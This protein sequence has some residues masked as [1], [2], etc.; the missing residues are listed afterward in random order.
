MV[1]WLVA[2]VTLFAAVPEATRSAFVEWAVTA[3]CVGLWTWGVRWL[4]TRTGEGPWPRAARLAARLLM[5]G[6]GK[7]PVY[8]AVPPSSP[9][10]GLYSMADGTTV[11]AM[12][13]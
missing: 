1:A 9:P 8:P 2:H 6:L 4:K 5:L 7:Q 13:Q 11:R 10:T 3:V 12:R